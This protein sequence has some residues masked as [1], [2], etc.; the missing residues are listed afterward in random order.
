MNIQTATELYIAFRDSLKYRDSSAKKSRV[1]H[2]IRE[3]AKFVGVSKETEQITEE[4]CI[5]FL[6]RRDTAVTNAWKK[7]HC[8]IKKLFEWAYL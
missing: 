5:S 6:N 4:D 3:F 1:K 2:S 7:E 8:A